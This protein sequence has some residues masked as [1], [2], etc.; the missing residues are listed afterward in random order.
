MIPT[1]YKPNIQFSL[2]TGLFILIIGLAV[3]LEQY[4]LATIP[5]VVLFFYASWQNKNAIFFLLLFALPFSFEYNF[6]STLGTDIPDEFLMLLVSGLFLAYWLYFPK[7]IS[8]NILTHPLI[9]FFFIGLCWIVIAVLFSTQ[10]I[11]SLK[12]MLA[13]GWYIGA[14]V[15]APLIIFNNKKT[16]TSSY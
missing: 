5:F 15:L 1:V 7:A 12:Y 9:I 6:T 14:F 8:K 11:I 13:K 16:I 4:Y 3:I 10:P 2:F